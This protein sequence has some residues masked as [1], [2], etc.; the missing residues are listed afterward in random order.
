ME[1]MY[2][3]HREK[4]KIFKNL[5]FDS[6]DQIMEGMVIKLNESPS[7]RNIFVYLNCVFEAVYR[8]Q[9]S[10]GSNIQQR[11]SM[12]CF[13]DYRIVYLYQAKLLLMPMIKKG[14][15]KIVVTEKKPKRS[16]KSKN[17]LAIPINEEEEKV[18]KIE[19][20]KQKLVQ[21]F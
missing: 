21:E 15:S 17:I 5:N 8:Y 3:I 13:R 4:F 1:L 20:L 12:E 16:Q 6:F 18:L 2:Y 9:W 14:K 7:T 11:M 19:E 10:R